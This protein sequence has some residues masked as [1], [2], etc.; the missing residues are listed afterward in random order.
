MIR[1]LKLLASIKGKPMEKLVTVKFDGEAHRVDVNTFASVLLTYSE[2]VDCAA[3]SSGI[4]DPVSV[5]I[6]ANEP[7]SLDVIVSVVAQGALDAINFITSNKDSIEAAILLAGAFYGLKKKFAGKKQIKIVGEDDDGKISIEADGQEIKVEKNVYNFYVNNPKISED[8]NKSFSVLDDNS[9]ITGIEIKSDG[10]PTFRADRSEFSAISE[11]PIYEIH[12]DRHQEKEAFLTVI[13]PCLVSDK[14]RKWEFI[15]DGEKLS[16]S[17][18]DQDFL[19]NLEK[20]S[21]HKG[22]TMYVKLDVFQEYVEEF[23]AF[24]NKSYTITKV[25]NVDNGVETPPML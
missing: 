5:Y 10:I 22:T 17:I 7:G 16:A 9:A 25:F 3:K 2:V 6:K 14:S 18:S 8:V 23:D 13:K 20:Y 12:T 19:D 4:L 21:F 24:I 11:S 1:L 15:N